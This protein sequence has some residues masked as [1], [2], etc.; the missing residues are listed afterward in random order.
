M[1]L[2]D[3]LLITNTV[4][5]CLSQPPF[6]TAWQQHIFHMLPSGGATCFALNYCTA[7]PQ[8]H[9]PRTKNTAPDSAGDLYYTAITVFTPFTQ[10]KTFLYSDKIW[11]R[12]RGCVTEV[13]LHENENKFSVQM[14]QRFHS[15]G[16]ATKSLR[17]NVT[18]AAN[19]KWMHL[20]LAWMS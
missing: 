9:S 12:L 8:K 7:D 20:F 6:V 5:K 13:K 3:P 2:F 17:I 1:T 15:K 16:G 19:S 11:S 10:H 4:I 14:I 18:C